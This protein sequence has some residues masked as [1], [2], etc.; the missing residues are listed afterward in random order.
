MHKRAA[1]AAGKNGAVDLLFQRLFAQDDRS[2]GPPQ[3]F[4]GRGGHHVGIGYRRRVYPRC[5]QPAYVGHVHEQI[6]AHLVADFP[7]TLKVNYAGI[8]RS[9]GDDHF[10]PAFLRPAENLVI[11]NLLGFPI[12]AVKVGLEVLAGDGGWRAVSQMPAMGKI[13]AQKNVARLHKRQI[14]GNICL[15][16]GMGLHIG[17]LGAKKGFGAFDGNAFHHVHIFTPAVKPPAGV[18][19][20]I[21]VCQMAA[22]SL[23]HSFGNKILRSDKFQ[24]CSLPF[25]LQRHCAEYFTVDPANMLVIH[26]YLRQN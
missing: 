11:I 6:C 15:G 26:L 2:A 9:A 25:N 13:H 19:L 20:G 10:R 3:S 22:D 17:V 14:N 18:S 8:S 24:V 23:H 4:M 16:T 21:F 1:L 5:H 12:N 7:H